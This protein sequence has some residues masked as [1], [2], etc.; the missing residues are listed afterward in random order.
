MGLNERSTTV[1]GCLED[2]QLLER[3]L[4]EYE[5][6]SVFH[7]GAQ[8]IVRTANQGPLSTFES[9][10]RGTYNLL[11]ASRNSNAI[12]SIVIASS[13]KA[14]GRQDK[15][16]YDES[17]PLKANHPYDVS[18]ACADMISRAYHDTYGLAVAITRCGNFFGGGD[19][20]FNRIVPG[21]IRSIL[22]GEQPIIRS[23][24]KMIRDYLYIEDAAH[25]YMLLSRALAEKKAGGQAFNFA[26]E[27]PISV[28]EL[29]NRML[30][31]YDSDLE[32][33]I[34]NIADNEIEKQYLSSKKAQNTLGWKP[35]H[36]LDEGL[37]KTYGW[38]SQYFRER[39]FDV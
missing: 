28:I 24:G 13:D 31:L 2:Y 35:R 20:N 12:D 22:F 6:E 39:G 26:N 32:P 34:K 11:E 27:T 19:L 16:P 7:L 9:N 18:K 10:I 21:T 14:Y 17:M 8:T 23:D 15:L 33:V 1:K 4:N 37:K 30:R 3:I 5:I 36:T 38:Y 29:V 25:G